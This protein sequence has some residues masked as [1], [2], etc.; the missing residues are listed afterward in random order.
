MAESGVVN[1]HGKEYLTVA[2][3]IADFRAA[4][5]NHTIKTKVLNASELVQVKATICDDT[6]RVIATGLAEEVRGSTN[7]NKTSALENAE[8]SAVGR[9]LA[10]FGLGGTEIA[11]A[12]EVANAIT[13][14]KEMEMVERL[15]RHNAAVREHLTSIVAIKDYLYEDNYSAAYEAIREL[16]Q[17]DWEALHI[18]TTKGGIWETE[19]RAKF[20]SNEM[21]DAR[22]TYHGETA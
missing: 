15:K 2:R 19:E 17:E 18:A 16:P 11:S 7:I 13:Q 20:K 22:K 5:P 14:Q 12:D 6:G 9:A 1:I 21:N 4:H 3:R 8:T 10:F